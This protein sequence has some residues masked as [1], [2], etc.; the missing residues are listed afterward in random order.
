MATKVN[1][2]RTSE[3]TVISPAGRAIQS[4]YAGPDFELPAGDVSI[5][6]EATVP[7]PENLPSDWIEVPSAEFGVRSIPHDGMLLRWTAALKAKKE[8]LRGYR[9]KGI[10]AHR[11]PYVIAVNACRLSSFG[12]TRGASGLPLAVEA[13]FPIGPWEFPILHEEDRLGDPVRSARFSIKNKNGKPVSTDSFLNPAYAGVS[14]VLGCST[15][16]APGEELELVVVHNPLAQVVNPL[17]VGILAA[18]TE[19][20]AERNGNEYVLK[21]IV[22]E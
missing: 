20:A 14:A 17:P 16:Y 6:I 22:P 3:C 2:G 9:E 7:S 21:R 10:V 5:W 12:T 4:R 18:A 13:V 11:D 1:F 19:Y 8:K 15:C